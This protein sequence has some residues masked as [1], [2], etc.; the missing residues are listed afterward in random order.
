MISRKN[1]MP[2]TV[3][4][5]RTTNYPKMEFD[6][7]GHE[8]PLLSAIQNQGFLMIKLEKLKNIYQIKL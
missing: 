7:N 3:D 8:G 4:E 2:K 5:L 1:W 6:L